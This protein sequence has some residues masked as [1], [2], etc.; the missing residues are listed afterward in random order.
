MTIGRASG[1]RLLGQDLTTATTPRRSPTFSGSD[2]RQ[3]C[4]CLLGLTAGIPNA[5]SAEAPAPPAPVEKTAAA[6]AKVASEPSVFD[7]IWKNAD[8]YSDEKN[9]VIQSFKF[10]GRFQLDH[11]WVDADEG[12]HDEWNIRR[13]RLGAKAKLFKDF[14]LHAESDLNPQEGNPTYIRM[15]DLYL[16]WSRS[17]NLTV[18]V[19]KHSAPFTMDG[20]TSSKELIAVDRGNVSNNLWFPEEYI[21]GVSVSGKPG[22]WRYHVG[23]YSAGDAS[24]E[25]GDFDGGTFGLVSGGY[26]FAEQLGVK[27][28]TL[29]LDYVHQEPDRQNNYTRGFDNIGSLNFSFATSKWG[30]RTDLAGGTAYF[31]GSDV[32]GAMVMPFYNITP[33]FQAVA[34]YTYLSS[35]DNNGVRLARYENVV[36]SGRGN[37]Y[38]EI[39]GGLNYYVYQHKLKFQTGI[40]YADM[41]DRANDGGEYRGFS[42]VTG[43]RIS[44]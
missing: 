13:F 18:T 26:N 22:N 30:V 40:Q 11:A 38:Q 8:I 7:K 37:E 43:L 2:F 27:D 33:K 32:W 12:E 20:A 25:F 36:V 15:T 4:V 19:G 44:W 14:M 28:A 1:K 42:W 41:Q 6:P 10:T 21:P 9:P 3:I 23:L 17:K 29:S 16:A 39:Y 35:S 34:R 31:N 5:V 24:S